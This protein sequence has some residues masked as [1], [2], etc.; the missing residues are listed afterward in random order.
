MNA[1]IFEI[2]A[3]NAEV[4]KVL[5]PSMIRMYMFDARPEKLTYPYATVQNFAGSAEMYLG[6]LPD[7]DTWSIQVDIFAKSTTEAKAVAKAIRNAIGP[8]SYITRWGIQSIDDETKSFRYSFD[9]DW[10]VLR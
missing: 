7:V 2:C 4:L 6:T 9:V 8:H 1:P 3:T 5:G 10:M